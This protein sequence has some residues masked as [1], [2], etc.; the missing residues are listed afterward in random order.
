MTDTSKQGAL[1]CMK[2]RLEDAGIPKEMLRNAANVA[3]R[4]CEQSSAADGSVLEPCHFADFQQLFQE[5]AQ[6]KIHP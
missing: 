6:K 2:T 1:A 4:F 5:L 3:A